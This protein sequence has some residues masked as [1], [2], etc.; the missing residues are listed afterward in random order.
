MIGLRMYDIIKHPCIEWINRSALKDNTASLLAK[1]PNAISALLLINL[2][3][4]AIASLVTIKPSSLAS[5]QSLTLSPRDINKANE[6]LFVM[7][8]VHGIFRAINIRG[9]LLY[10][11][12]V[13]LIVLLLRTITTLFL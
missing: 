10:Y 5:L 12:K 1:Y 11:G 4:A 3:L 8:T 7:M 13:I 6:R 2:P 9:D